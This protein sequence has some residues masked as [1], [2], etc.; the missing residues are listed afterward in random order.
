MIGRTTIV[1]IGEALRVESPRGADAGGLAA[2]TA[3]TAVRL[4]HTGVA[5]TRLGQD[6]AGEEILTSLRAKG[7]TVEHIQSDPDL[8]TGRLTVRSIA[9]RTTQTLS[10][11]AAFDNLQW[12]FDLVDLGQEASG[13]IFGEL[14]RRGGQTRSVIMQFLAGCAGA[15]RVYDA[16]NRAADAVAD[17]VQMQSALEFTDVVVADGIALRALVPSWSPGRIGDAAKDL[18]AGWNLSAVIGV[19]RSGAEELL[20]A[21][22]REGTWTA[23]NPFPA[24]AHQTAMAG[25]AHALM[26]GQDLP[27]CLETATA[28][29]G[30]ASRHPDQ[31]F[32]PNLVAGG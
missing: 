7:V 2:L 5:V 14:A 27:S 4:G 29:A 26:K 8:A 30:H 24:S 32:P 21:H 13:V 1:G 25:L 9:G 12:D 23:A 22:S 17:R 19:E 10:P 11:W 18:L 16:V 6:S 28:L 20:S 3:V 15:V 31:E